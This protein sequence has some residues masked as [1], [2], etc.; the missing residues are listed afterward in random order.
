[1]FLN[2]ITGAMPSTPGVALDVILGNIP[3]T[4]WLEESARGALRLKTLNHW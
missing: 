4:L 3:I 1:M 2:L